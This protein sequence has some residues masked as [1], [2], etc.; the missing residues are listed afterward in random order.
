M[1]LNLPS[2]RALTKNTPSLNNVFQ[3]YNKELQTARH[4]A[5][6]CPQRLSDLDAKDL[7]ANGLPDATRKMHMGNTQHFG[8]PSVPIRCAR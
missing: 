8:S 1:S 3:H 2:L 6:F 5:N 7:D 4:Q